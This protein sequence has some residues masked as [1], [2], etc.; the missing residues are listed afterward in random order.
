MPSDPQRA[1]D[2]HPLDSTRLSLQRERDGPRKH[3][4]EEERKVC[5]REGNNSLKRKK[6]EKANKPK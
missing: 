5:V 6:K 1:S 2:T 3:D 4:G